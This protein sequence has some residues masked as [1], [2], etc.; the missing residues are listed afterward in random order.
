M[1]TRSLAGS[2]LALLAILLVSIVHA[3]EKTPA[4]LVLGR[5]G[6]LPIILTA[7]HGGREGIPG[8]EPRRAVDRSSKKWG[9]VH[10]GGDPETDRL[11]EG[12]AAEL[13][14]LTGREPYLVVA[15][16][17]RKY[18][19]A[20]RPPDLAFE[21]RRA[22]PYY[23]H[24]HRRIREFVDE[25]RKGHG[26]GLLIDV[27]GQDK[28]PEVVMRGT[29]NGRT[30]ARLTWRAG[31][32][33]VTG[34]KGIFGQLEAKGFTVFPANHLPI[35]GRNEDA[36]FNGGYTVVTYGSQNGDGIDAIQLEFGAAYRRKAVVD[37]SARD[38]ARAIA[39]FYEAYLQRAARR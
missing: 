3:E 22:R 5:R 21:D 33:A 28:D 27:H 36:G 20:N 11:A 15:R 6:D 4:D 2:G 17:L 39:G 25:I 23:D 1:C 8:V 10:T 18:I 19:D 24:Y 12:I 16:F 38:A 13:R 34:A 14:A 37:R 35:Q 30:V 31:E 29:N 32:E 7:P 26:A 9:G